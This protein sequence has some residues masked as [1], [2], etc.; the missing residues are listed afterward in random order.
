MF[1]HKQGKIND[2]L[3]AKQFADHFS[4]VRA[5][6]SSLRAVELKAAYEHKRPC[7]LGNVDDSRYDA[8]LVKN[9][10]MKMKRGKAAGLDNITVE[11]LRFSHYILYCV[12]CKLFNFMIHCSH[13]PDCFGMSYTV[14]VMKNNANTNNKTITVD[15]FRGISISPV[16]SKVFEH[17]VLERY[18]SLCIILK[19]D[20]YGN[21][22]SCFCSFNAV[23]NVNIS[24]IS[25]SILLSPSRLFGTCG[26]M[27]SV[28]NLEISSIN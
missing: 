17:Y 26:S 2:R 13:V 14:P 15:D 21:F 28:S 9:A 16:I 10:I 25:R 11:H 23:N 8:Q 3:I 20:G 4:N 24:S 12:L 18:C 19:T 1:D 5:N 27:T 7:Y 22:S 6:T